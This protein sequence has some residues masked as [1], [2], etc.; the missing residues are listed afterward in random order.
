MPELYNTM[1]EE[2]MTVLPRFEVLTGQVVT[3]QVQEKLQMDDI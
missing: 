3:P 1:R 2:I